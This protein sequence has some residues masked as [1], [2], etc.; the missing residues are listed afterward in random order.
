MTSVLDGIERDVTRCCRGAGGE[1][2][3][4]HYHVYVIELAGADGAPT[5]PPSVYVGQS[6]RAPAVRFA[7]H[8]CGFRSARCV[9]RGGLWLRWRLF[10]HWNPLSTRV[11]AEQAERRLGNHLRDKGY[12]VKGGH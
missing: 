3:A 1:K 5:C 2:G 10:Q 8:R 9:K 7:Q 6:V 12:A 11:E 4:Q